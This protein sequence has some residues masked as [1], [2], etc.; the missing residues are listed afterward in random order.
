MAG[1]HQIRSWA[2]VAEEVDHRI[3][4]MVAEAVEEAAHLFQGRTR[5]QE[6]VGVV[7][8]VDKFQ[9][10]AKAEVEDLAELDSME[11]VA[12]VAAV[13]CSN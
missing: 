3:Q 12:A 9:T 7:A 10:W 13:E 2:L 1:V 5:N 4:G 11:T 6:A 8:V